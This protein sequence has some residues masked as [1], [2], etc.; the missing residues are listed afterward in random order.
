M[1][2]WLRILGWVISWPIAATVI[3]VSLVAGVISIP[4]AV[5][6][7]DASLPG[8][9][10]T[11][12]GAAT[13]LVA[14]VLMLRSMRKS[15]HREISAQVTSHVRRGAHM[16]QSEQWG[17]IEHERD[18]LELSPLFSDIDQT[19]RDAWSRALVAAVVALF[20]AALAGG[21]CLCTDYR[22]VAKVTLRAHH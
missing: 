1:R 9:G 8:T 11:K 13:G 7:I 15:F 12:L 10:A 3:L 22:L 16:S 6:V 14:Y 4:L 5:M 17:S 18:R 2:K 20:P 19:V 21:V